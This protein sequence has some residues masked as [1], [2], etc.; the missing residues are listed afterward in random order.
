[1]RVGESRGQAW[2][3]YNTDR[4]MNYCGEGGVW[5]LGTG[6]R[7]EKQSWGRRG[8]DP[9]G[10]YLTLGRA[11]R[12]SRLDLR[13]SRALGIRK[14]VVEKCHLLLHFLNL[15]CMLVEDVFAHKLGALGEERMVLQLPDP[16]QEA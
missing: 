8:T 4:N 5:K 3:E 14:E 9:H 6:S 13:Q 10:S 11:R 12:L 15:L 1:M 2:G 16:I 7:E